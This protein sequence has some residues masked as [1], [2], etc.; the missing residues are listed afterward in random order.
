MAFS[1][2]KIFYHYMFLMLALPFYY[3][4]PRRVKAKSNQLNTAGFWYDMG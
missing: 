4:Q 3:N 1:V 2:F